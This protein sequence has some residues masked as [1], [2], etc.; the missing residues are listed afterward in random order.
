MST[1]REGLDRDSTKPVLYL[2]VHELPKFNGGRNKLLSFIQHNIQWPTPEFDYTGTVLTSFVVERNGEISNI[3][4]E[5]KLCD[6]CD[7]EAI[8]LI[9]KMPN[10]IPGKIDGKTVNVLIY[11]PIEFKLRD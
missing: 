9:K 10:W 1:T 11:L 6:P 4:V 5:R 2:Y 8:R 7:Q 3:K